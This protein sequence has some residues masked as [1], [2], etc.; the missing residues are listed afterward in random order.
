MKVAVVIPALDDVNVTDCNNCSY[1]ATEAAPVN[2]TELVP[3]VAVT[4][5]GKVP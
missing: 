4:P 2:V 3:G 1:A 5:D